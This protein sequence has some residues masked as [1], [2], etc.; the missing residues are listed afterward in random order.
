MSTIV[1]LG[2]F[3]LREATASG[4]Q[5]PALRGDTANTASAG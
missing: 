3:L 2:A 1:E 5:S 4:T